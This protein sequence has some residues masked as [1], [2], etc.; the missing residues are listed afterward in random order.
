MS[1]ADR[2]AIET[3]RMQLEDLGRTV[4]TQRQQ[5]ELLTK[6][7]SDVQE[8]DRVEYNSQLPAA[9]WTAGERVGV[10][11]SSRPFCF[12]PTFYAPCTL[13]RNDG[14]GW[15]ILRDGSDKLEFAWNR[16]LRRLGDESE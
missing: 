5:I 7:K 3:L 6:W 9:S 13:V 8:K 15:M 11:T 2:Q 1:W 12:P 4:E 10:F 14:H 16:D